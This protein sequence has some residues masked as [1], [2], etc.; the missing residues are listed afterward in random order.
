MQRY[1][2][3][4]L[5]LLQVVEMASEMPEMSTSVKEH[6]NEMVTRLNAW[7]KEKQQEMGNCNFMKRSTSKRGRKHG[8][9]E[10]SGIGVDYDEGRIENN[11]P[12]LNST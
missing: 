7:K 9:Y 4:R 3:L 12:I 6:A 2:E 5:V 1:E 10:T 8:G 11:L